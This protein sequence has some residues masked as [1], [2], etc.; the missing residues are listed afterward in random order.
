MTWVPVF[1]MKSGGTPTPP[2]ML[3]GVRNYLDIVCVEIYEGVCWNPA[4]MLTHDIIDATNSSG[5]N[6]YFH[7]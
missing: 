5:R 4:K 7:S 6:K 3:A 1:D 2:P